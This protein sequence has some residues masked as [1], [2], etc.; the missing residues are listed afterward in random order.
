ML[1]VDTA[2]AD[3]PDKRQDPIVRFRLA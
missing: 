1:D 3:A 2:S